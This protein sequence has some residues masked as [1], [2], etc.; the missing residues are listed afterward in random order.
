MQIQSI[1]APAIIAAFLTGCTYTTSASGNLST[2]APITGSVVAGS[3]GNRLEFLPRA[4]VT[5][6]GSYQPNRETLTRVFPLTCNDGTT[7]EARMTV[8]TVQGGV[9]RQSTETS[10]VLS[11]GL[12][13]NLST[14]PWTAA[15][16]R[17]VRAEDRRRASC[18]REF[19]TRVERLEGEVL[20]ARVNLSRGYAIYYQTVPYTYAGTCYARGGSYSCMR[21]GSRTQETPV[22]INPQTE[23]QRLVNLERELSAARRDL[24][25]AN[26]SC[27]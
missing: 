19:T 2:G 12:R 22:S 21:N 11:N 18:V 6:V 17:A 5:C 26:T 1:L 15:D 25:R 13:G 4:G 20:T 24:Q 23:R 9:S 7:G 14:S 3:D 16:E 10:F 27:S 8:S